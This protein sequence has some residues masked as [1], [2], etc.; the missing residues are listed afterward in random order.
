MQANHRFDLHALTRFFTDHC[1]P[2]RGNPL[3]LLSAAQIV[4]DL[5]AEQLLALR[6]ALSGAA[7][8]NT[9]AQLIEQRAATHA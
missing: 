2:G 9:L 4:S 6:A 7:L 3:S 8:E 5:P 1:Q